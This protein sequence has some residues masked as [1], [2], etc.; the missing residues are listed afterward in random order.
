MGP[1]AADQ[2]SHG[3][4]GDA[5]LPARPQGEPHQGAGGRTG[6]GETERQIIAVY[7]DTNKKAQIITTVLRYYVITAYS[8]SAFECIAAPSVMSPTPR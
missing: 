5:A 2:G 4:H 6:H 3:A 8:Q 7:E 1:A